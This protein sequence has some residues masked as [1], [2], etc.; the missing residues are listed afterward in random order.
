MGRRFALTKDGEYFGSERNNRMTPFYKK[1]VFYPNVLSQ[2]I[3]AKPN[4]ARDSKPRQ[5]RV[6]S[7]RAYKAWYRMKWNAYKYDP[8][9]ESVSNFIADMGEAPE[10]FALTRINRKLPYS[11]ENC[12]WVPNALRTRTQSNLV[13]NG[14]PLTHREAAQLFSVSPSYFCKKA[15]KFGIPAQEA[16]N[17]LLVK[18][19]PLASLQAARSQS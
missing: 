16:L 13:L 8:R 4:K 12:K 11:K 2:E 1:Y 19:M 9:W 15:K 5:K 18:S 14:R 10:D 3:A 7:T 6:K 17:Q